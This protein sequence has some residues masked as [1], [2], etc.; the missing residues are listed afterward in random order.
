MRSKD[1]AKFMVDELVD[2]LE[3]HEQRKKKKEET[4]DPAHQTKTSLKDEKVLYSQ[5]IQ[6]RGRGSRENG[7]G[8]EDSRN[9]EIYK[10][11]SQSSQT[12]WRGRGR[13]QGY[14]SNI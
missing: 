1:L 10:E 12:N 11:K 2:S 6:G 14:N 5:N 3:A 7:R 8:G 13:S 4:F 9:E